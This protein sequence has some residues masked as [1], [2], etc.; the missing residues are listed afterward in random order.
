MLKLIA[1]VLP[2]CLDTF[3]VA[4][5]L[6][7]GGLPHGKRLRLT[8]LLASFE[9]LMP[10]VGVAVGQGLGRAVGAHADYIA[11]AAL[12]G[13]GA[14]LLLHDDDDEA[15]KAATLS[16]A[17]GIAVIGLGIGISLD[18]LAVGFSIGLLRVP[19]V[20]A[21]ALIA[22]QAFAAAQIGVR[23]GAHLSEVAR[24]RAE[25]IAAITLICL[26]L[27]ILTARAAR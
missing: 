9:A 7:A 22:V 27:A 2:L 13:F 15:A 23:V 19:I 10:L 8:L 16:R 21:I 26:G 3:V 24:G 4:A 1:L 6:G 25:R 11:S 5:A 18:E 12:I 17:H 14:F 20:W